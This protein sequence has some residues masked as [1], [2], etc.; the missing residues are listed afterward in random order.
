M[1]VPF[2]YGSGLGGYHH[3]RRSANRSIVR[4]NVSLPSFRATLK[5]VMLSLRWFMT[6]SHWPCLSSVSI[7]RIV[8]AG[9]DIVLMA[10]ATVGHHRK[11]GNAVMQAVGDVE[12]LTVAA[13]D[14]PAAKLVPL[15]SLG[16][17]RAFSPRVTIR[18]AYQDDR[19]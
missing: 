12:L 8:A 10:Q 15:Y 1:S 11:V 19:R 4:E 7:T 18:F 13:Q 16:S 17:A 5:R 2:S 14:R 6:Y 9:P 3:L